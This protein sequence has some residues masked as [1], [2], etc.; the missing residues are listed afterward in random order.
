MEWEKIKSELMEDL[1][2]QENQ[3]VTKD[4]QLGT[5]NS[6]RVHRDDNNTTGSDD[7]AHVTL[8]LVPQT[9]SLPQQILQPR[10]RTAL[11]K[12]SQNEQVTSSTGT[13]RVMPVRSSPRNAQKLLK[14]TDESPES[15][16]T[17]QKIVELI[18][19]GNQTKM[20]NQVLGS[21]S[22]TALQQPGEDCTPMHQL[23]KRPIILFTAKPKIEP[24]EVDD[25]KPDVT[26]LEKHLKKTQ[27]R[28]RGKNYVHIS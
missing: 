2:K 4:E 7:D 5:I 16:L 8:T 24:P 23:R 12:N 18:Q 19:H 25:E 21:S 13:P 17:K 14:S 10:N 15:G 3:E 6:G 9:H 11:A 1:V 20:A 28:V 26:E 22:A 27:K